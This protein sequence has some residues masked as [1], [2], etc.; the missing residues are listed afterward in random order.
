MTRRPLDAGTALVAGSLAFILRPLRAELVL[1]GMPSAGSALLHREG[2]VETRVREVTPGVV[3]IPPAPS[4]VVR[5]VS[6]SGLLE[7]PDLGAVHEL[8]PG[9]VVEIPE[10]VRAIV[11]ATTV[12]R[13]VVRSRERR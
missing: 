5:V 8:A 4:A 7:L 2:G 12:L 11:T 1:L 6:G 13:A 9:A 3:R 10:G